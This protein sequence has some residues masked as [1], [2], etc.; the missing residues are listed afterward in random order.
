MID[1]KE[2]AWLRLK[3]LEMSDTYQSTDDKDK[4]IINT[5]SVNQ[6]RADKIYLW[7]TTGE[8]NGCA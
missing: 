8:R 1:E 7:A 3:C 4:P 6:D 2:Q 5:L